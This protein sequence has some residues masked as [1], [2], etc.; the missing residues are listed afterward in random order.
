[1]EGGT[2][3]RPQTLEGWT[4][5]LHCHPCRLLHPP[6]LHPTVSQP[7]LHLTCLQLPPCHT[8]HLHPCPLFPSKFLVLLSP[9]TIHC[10]HSTLTVVASVLQAAGTI[11]ITSPGGMDF[12]LSNFFWSLWE[13]MLVVLAICLGCVKWASKMSGCH[14]KILCFYMNNIILFKIEKL[15]KMNSDFW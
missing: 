1:M 5:S 9:C 2:Q 10:I 8:H 11:C 14:S 6:L 7:S 3:S 4:P 15:K 12:V 13:G